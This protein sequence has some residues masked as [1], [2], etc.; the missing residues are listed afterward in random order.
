MLLLDKQSVPS[1]IGQILEGEDLSLSEHGEA[2]IEHDRENDMWQIVERLSDSDREVV[3]LGVEKNIDQYVATTDA[4]KLRVSMIKTFPVA[5]RAVQIMAERLDS[6]VSIDELRNRILKESKNLIEGYAAYSDATLAGLRARL[7]VNESGDDGSLEAEAL[8]TY[9]ELLVSCGYGEEDANNT[10]N[11]VKAKWD[12]LAQQAEEK[13][14]NSVLPGDIALEHYTPYALGPILGGG[15]KPKDEHAVTSVNRRSRYVH[16]TSRGD[17]AGAWGTDISSY[18]GVRSQTLRRMDEDP[19]LTPLSGM[20]TLPLAEAIEN[21]FK[22]AH[23]TPKVIDGK[24]HIND[25]V[26]GDSEGK[27]AKLA[28]EKLDFVPTAMSDPN[29]LLGDR[30]ARLPYDTAIAKR[31]NDLKAVYEPQGPLEWSEFV[32]RNLDSIAIAKQVLIEQGANPVWVNEHVRSKEEVRQ[33]SYRLQAGVIVPLALAEM[34]KENIDGKLD[35]SDQQTV[36]L[37][38][39]KADI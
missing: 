8:S 36:F 17:V 21:G 12:T 19:D 16:F 38:V 14:S 20:F 4:I 37:G 25:I 32:E 7:R 11:E 31:L 10:L 24:P 1:L 23:F 28:L 15:L 34:E 35:R 6:H 18:T 27:T 5:H 33:A 30:V 22:T 9:R 13:F 29:G 2:A 26:L 39:V 3:D